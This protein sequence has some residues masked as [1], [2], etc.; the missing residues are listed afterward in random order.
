[1]ARPRDAKSRKEPGGQDENA[2]SLADLKRV[3][4]CPRMDGEGDDSDESGPF[5]IPVAQAIEEL[6]GDSD[7]ET[8]PSPRTIS[9]SRR[10]MLT[11]RWMPR[12][13]I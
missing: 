2:T 3:I 11:G 9:H 10:A 12:A 8:E 6:D 4:G 5:N 7:A 1:M 13:Y